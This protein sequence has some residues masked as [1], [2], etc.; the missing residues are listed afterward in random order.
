MARLGWR[1]APQGRLEPVTQRPAWR[2]CMGLAGR[3]LGSG[4]HAQWRM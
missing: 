2:L 3:Q 1:F 4:R